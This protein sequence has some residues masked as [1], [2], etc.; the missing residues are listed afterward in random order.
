MFAAPR[1]YPGASSRAPKRSLG[2]DC[3]AADSARGGLIDVNGTFYETT[4]TGG[5][6]GNGTVFALVP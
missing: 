1:R 2:W 4:S 6:Y 5:T 3:A